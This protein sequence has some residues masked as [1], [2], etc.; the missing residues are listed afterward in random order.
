MGFNFGDSRSGGIRKDPGCGGRARAL[1]AATQ[2]CN[3]FFGFLVRLSLH[4]SI[5]ISLSLPLSGDVL[6]GGVARL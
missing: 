2:D 6:V 4:G 5:S 1:V 3:F